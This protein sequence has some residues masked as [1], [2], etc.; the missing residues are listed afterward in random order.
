MDATTTGFIS[1][2]FVFPILKSEEIL[3]LMGELGFAMSKVE[4]M[5]PHRHKERLRQMYLFLVRAGWLFV[6]LLLSVEG[7]S[8]HTSPHSSTSVRARPRMIC[9]RHRP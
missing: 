1:K 5:E 3:Q 4:L 6:C 8:S 7:Q 2:G 9:S